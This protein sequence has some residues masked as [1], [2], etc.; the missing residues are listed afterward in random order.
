MLDNKSSATCTVY[1]IADVGHRSYDKL[2]TNAILSAAGINNITAYG[3]TTTI[4]T[5]MTSCTSCSMKN[6]DG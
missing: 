5:G 2:V 6:L 3:N 4:G 1:E